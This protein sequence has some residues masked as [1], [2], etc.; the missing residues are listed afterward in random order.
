MTQ[1]YLEKGN[2]R[3]PIRSQTYELLI[4]S[5]D[6]LPLSYRRLMGAKA[7]KLG[8]WDKHHFQN[9]HCNT[10]KFSITLSSHAEDMQSFKFPCQAAAK[11][12]RKMS[13]RISEHSNS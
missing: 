10:C 1:A 2:P 13:G 7:I 6:A 9:I 11:A 12:S 3:A 5:S 4:T 8:S